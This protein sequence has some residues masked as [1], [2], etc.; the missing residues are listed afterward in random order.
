[1]REQ[2]Q[3][4][5]HTS[6]PASL[7]SWAGTAEAF[8]IPQSFDR[9]KRMEMETNFPSKLLEASRFGKPLILWGPPW[10][11]AIRWAQDTGAALV[12]TDPDPEKL[13]EAIEMLAADNAEQKRLSDAITSVVE[14][15]FNPSY[16]QE[17][18]VRALREAAQ[19]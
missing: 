10:G 12:L 11:S 14:T 6:D 16:L 17:S 8:L 13:T 4:L 9:D 7:Q 15:Q 5:S 1:M 3:L 2:G 19:R 18:F